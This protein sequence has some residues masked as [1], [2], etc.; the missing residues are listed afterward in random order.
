[1]RI[2]DFVFVVKILNNYLKTENFQIFLVSSV[3]LVIFIFRK[4]CKIEPN[5][6]PK[7]KSK[8]EP[9]NLIKN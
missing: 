4:K 1:M 6:K 2:T 5:Q 8:T 7:T 3:I 9:E